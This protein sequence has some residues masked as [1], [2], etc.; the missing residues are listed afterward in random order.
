M[1]P[2][3]VLAKALAYP[4]DPPRHS[5]VFVAGRGL[6]LVRNGP[7]LFADAHV[8]RDGTHVHLGTTLAELGAGE[9][10]GMERR[11][12]VVG[13][14]SNASAARLAEKF[15]HGPDHVI[16]VLRCRL[17]DHDVVYATHF[18]SYGSLPA[19]V[20]ASQGTVA[21]VSVSFLTDHQLE[22]MHAS[23]GDNYRFGELDAAIE[24]DGLGVL[25]R[26]SSY[27]TVHG[28]CGIDGAPVA[29]AAVEAANRRFAAL[30]QRSALERACRALGQEDLDAFVNAMV[31][32]K[33]HRLE[34]CQALRRYAIGHGAEVMLT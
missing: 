13:Y 22:V 5:F 29:L 31:A 10:D 11:T 6:K 27:I 14:G 26:P 18:A 19:A 12:P 30:D 32:D 1:I 4:F 21:E 25:E 24:V 3:P 34:M 9:T 28:V 17:H 7:D 16:P 8:E 23:E 2:S 33:A 15:G 20:Y